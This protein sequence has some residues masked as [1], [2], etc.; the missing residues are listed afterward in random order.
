VFDLLD[1]CE[2]IR[3]HIVEKNDATD[4]DVLRLLSG[5]KAL[6]MPS[7]AE[8]FGMPVQEALTLGTPVI[9]S[10]LNAI[11]EFA[12]DIPEYIEPHDGAQWLSTIEDYA[13]IDS[14]L[15]NQQI[16]RMRGFQSHSWQEHFTLVE[17]FLSSF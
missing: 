7:Y 1:R 3:P 11:R 8:G 5:A 17:A 10:P 16:A 6:L 14:S 12:G 4:E 9:T 2:S 13:K 15:R